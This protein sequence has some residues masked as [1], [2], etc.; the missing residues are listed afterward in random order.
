MIDILAGNFSAAGA[1]S[2]WLPT[3]GRLHV[4][5]VH[6]P[7]TLLLLAGVIE[8]WRSVRRAQQPSRLAV[9]CLALGGGFAILAAWMGWLHKKYSGAGGGGLAATL[10][11]HEWLGFAAAGVGPAAPLVFP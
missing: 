5:V 10:T 4:V 6:F 3:L 9:I 7:I 11:V 2:P 8:L 1:S